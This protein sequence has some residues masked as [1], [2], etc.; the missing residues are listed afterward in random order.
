M[1]SG[2]GFN[3]NTDWRADY[4][5]HGGHSEVLAWAKIT[6]PRVKPEEELEQHAGAYDSLV[7]TI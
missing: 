3:L 7:R 6:L 4:I 2:G 1:L 5:L